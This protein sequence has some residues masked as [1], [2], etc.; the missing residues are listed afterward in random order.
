[1]TRRKIFVGI[2]GA[3][4]LVIAGAIT[5][6]FLQKGSPSV[7]P[8]TG[9]YPVS[10]GAIGDSIT[11]G[12]NT[13]ETNKPTVANNWVT[14]TNSAVNSIAS[15]IEKQ[16][17][18]VP[19]ISNVAVSGDASQDLAKQVA[20]LNKTEPELATILIGANDI[21]ISGG[22]VDGMTSVETF[23]SR[24]HDAL[25]AINPETKVFVAS[26]V[27]L[28]GL[29]TAGGSSASARAVWKKAAI[30]QVLL[31]DPTADDAMTIDRRSA[32][33]E[34]IDAYNDVLK[35]ECVQRLNC[36]YDDGALH[37]TTFVFSDLSSIDYFHPSIAGQAKI[38]DTLWPFIQRM[39]QQ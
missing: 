25:Q 39:Y 4:V 19:T 5:V 7:S 8:V 11:R 12:F 29:L 3:L 28:Q 1:M 32:V 23:Q 15:R 6:F 27:D 36:V 34:R 33:G 9:K 2:A 26:V 21:C 10:I 13:S 38:A 16:S 22:T 18:T 24:I 37:G 20:N 17:G 30:C 35:T 31:A 14:G